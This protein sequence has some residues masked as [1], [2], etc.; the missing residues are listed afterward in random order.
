VADAVENL[1]FVFS[2][3]DLASGVV[4]KAE[5]NMEAAVTTAEAHVTDLADA[6]E[7]ATQT[8]GTSTDSVV[9]AI[10]GGFNQTN[11][12]LRSL[13][14]ALTTSTDE[15]LAATGAAAEGLGELDTAAEDAKK[16]TDSLAKSSEGLF[17]KLN[18]VQGAIG[19]IVKLGGIG[20]IFGAG[21]GLGMKGITALINLISETLQPAL[22]ILT[23][24]FKT[25]F[26]PVSEELYKL[27]VQVAPLLTKAIM[28]VVDIL[29]EII[30]HIGNFVADLTAGGGMMGTVFGGLKTLFDNL[31]APVMTIVETLGNLA[32]TVLPVLLRVFNMIVESAVVPILTKVANILAAVIQR[33]APIIEKL[34]LKLEPIF[35]LVI[36]AVAEVADILLDALLPAMEPILD[37]LDEMLPDL[38]PLLKEM[39]VAWLEMAKALV[40]I[41][42]PLI[43]LVALLV[44]KVLGPVALKALG[45]YIKLWTEVY[46]LIAKL[47]TPAI[48]WVARFLADI[49]REWDNMGLSA[50]ETLDLIWWGVKQAWEWI[51]DKSKWLSEKVIG[52]FTGIPDMLKGAFTSY[53]DWLKGAYESIFKFLG[54]EST[55]KIA[56][57]F[58]DTLKN[59][60]L[61]PIDTIKAI[62]NDTIIDTINTILAWKVPVIGGTLAKNLGLNTLPY[63]QQ[64]GIVTEP[65][66]ATLVEKGIPEA[67]VPLEPTYI[68]RFM[69]SVMPSLGAQ[70]MGP[71]EVR[72]DSEL[73][74]LLR[75]AVGFLAKI[76][77][78]LD[79]GEQRRAP[80][81]GGGF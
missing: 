41:L 73:K 70:E 42:P 25:A 26:A 9:S 67:V 58:I 2:A 10:Q 14:M 55:G 59:L 46:K 74:D 49:A 23:N 68:Q 76:A 47:L 12:I 48:K 6:A 50:K 33:L 80:S 13:T 37:M 72:T 40:P 1:G 29:T 30:P 5:E 45:M 43:K 11:L 36:E 19:S 64:G 71:V 57:A 20:M 63:L 22:E 52:F 62:I 54:L 60:V 81:L 24:A 32:K 16:G 39:V 69:A 28:P 79:E 4:S 56:G 8:I 21:F 18:F 51:V 34:I 66:V 27:A 44:G 35:G 53:M 77:T 31:R 15:I 3:K 61:A 17:G 7:D 78:K 75:E 38:V 65:T